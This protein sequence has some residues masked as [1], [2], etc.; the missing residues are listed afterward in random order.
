MRRLAAALVFVSSSAAADSP[1][2]WRAGSDLIA[3]APNAA[4]L[5]GAWSLARQVDT[6]I[7]DR[8]WEP[9]T[10][11]GLTGHFTRRILY[12][13]T[14]TL[15]LGVESVAVVVAAGPKLDWLGAAAY[16]LDWM[17][18]VDLPTCPRIGANAGCGLGTGGFAFLQL[19]PIGSRWWFEAGGGSTDQRVS[20]DA[21]RTVGE[22]TWVLTPIAALRELET[23]T[24]AIASVRALVGAGVYGG[25]HNASMHPTARGEDA[26]GKQPWTELHPLE[27]GIG[28]GGVVDVTFALLRRITL[29]GDL[30]IA[31]FLL[32]ATVH[33]V[34]SAVAPLDR[35]RSGIPVWRKLDVG[36]GYRLS[37]MTMSVVGFAEELSDRPIVKAGSRGGMLRFDVR[38]R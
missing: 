30:T 17:L 14:W 31:P 32:G 10:V 8:A 34:S 23:P 29:A 35:P 24:D 26:F 3:T 27:G 25:M 18:P 33:R 22:S 19:R 4:L 11:A 6:L 5:D 15:M 2:P 9:P 13:T 21:L 1:R 38:L 7:V 16:R 12:G 37:N 28:P 36:V 20:S